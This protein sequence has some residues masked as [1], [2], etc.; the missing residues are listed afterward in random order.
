M[1][2]PNRTGV[3]HRQD[4]A[5]SLLQAAPAL[6]QLLLSGPGAASLGW[7]PL[8][9]GPLVVIHMGPS[10]TAAL[11]PLAEAPAPVCTSKLL[12]SWQILTAACS[13]LICTLTSIK[14]FCFSLT[15]GHRGCATSLRGPGQLTSRGHVF[16]VPCSSWGRSRQG[17]APGYHTSHTA[18]F[19]RG[20]RI[21]YACSRE[22][23]FGPKPPA[24]T[25]PS[26]GDG[27]DSRGAGCS[28]PSPWP[29]LGLSQQ[30]KTQ[31]RLLS[32]Q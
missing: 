9:P 16:T 26:A 30:S 2:P 12:R 25:A 10:V 3:P 19:G 20:E 23:A 17:G 13:R 8:T 4:P 21:S 28:K 31:P 27:G 7:G 24:H 29:A 1:S 32:Q 11:T 6:P 18:S 14:S 5:A 15:A 22:M